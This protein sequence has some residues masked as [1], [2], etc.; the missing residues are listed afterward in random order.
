MYGG[1][2]YGQEPYA[3]DSGAVE[4]TYAAAVFADHPQ[5]YWR[6][7]EASGALIDSSGHGHDGTHTGTTLGVTG[8]LTADTDTAA[9]YPNDRTIHSDVPWGAWLNS[10][11]LSVEAVI[12]PNTVISGSIV[13]RD[14]YSRPQT[15]FMALSSG[16]LAGFCFDSAGNFV[17]IS[18]ATTMVSGSIYHVVVTFSATDILVYVAGTQDGQIAMTNPVRTSDVS[19]GISIGAQ[20]ETPNVG[21]WFTPF[22]GVIDE[23]AFYD[24]VLSPTQIA[25]HAAALTGSG[26]GGSAS[27]AATGSLSLSG[28]VGAVAASG[29]TG[30][31]TL[32]GTADTAVAR[33]ATGSM[34]LAG[35]AGDRAAT[36]ATGSM[37][38]SGTAGSLAVNAANGALTLGGSAGPAV[39]AGAAGSMILAAT[40]PGSDTVNGVAGS[41]ALSAVSGASARPAATGALTLAGVAGAGVRGVTIGLIALVGTAT[42]DFFHPVSANATLTLAGIVGVAVT[43]GANG[44]MVLT[45]AAGEQSPAQAAG[46]ITLVGSGGAG[47]GTGATGSVVLFGA[48]AAAGSPIGT[49]HLSLTGQAGV[50]TRAAAV[51]GLTLFGIAGLVVGS[52]AQG[53]LTLGVKAPVF[54]NGYDGIAILGIYTDDPEDPYDPLS[55]LGAS[56]VGDGRHDSGAD[57]RPVGMR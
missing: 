10:G 6:L 3:G 23:V 30:S 9:S 51:G 49:G 53:F 38:I 7:G 2:A 34:T 15:W 32:S 25:N 13:T 29:A 52:A 1:Q 57:M 33:S 47:F 20:D 18:G 42:V 26:G 39:T 40:A 50:A 48:A 44:V 36:G 8:L 21:A 16:K 46:S 41:L 22:D 19:T 37:S 31:L 24:Y 43:A 27:A 5:G 17:V 54:T 56:L 14:G 35:T 11:E 55:L 45:G 4:T 28:S 12:K